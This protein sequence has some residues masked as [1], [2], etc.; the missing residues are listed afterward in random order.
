MAKYRNEIGSVID[1][2]DDKVT[3]IKDDVNS[4]LTTASKLRTMLNENEYDTS[5][6]F[7]YI[8]KLVDELQETWDSLKKLS[9]DLY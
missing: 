1:I 3:L 8:D 6:A 2:I 7:D 4:I 9:D 5:L